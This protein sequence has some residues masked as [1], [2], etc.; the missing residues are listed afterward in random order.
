[1]TDN[2]DV[3]A[4][5]PCFCCPRYQ[6]LITWADHLE[7]IA[8][9][10]ERD[11]M[12]YLNVKADIVEN[13]WDSDYA[14]VGISGYR[15][16]TVPTQNEAALIQHFE[17]LPAEVIFAE[18]LTPVM[19][20][21]DVARPGLVSV[22]REKAGYAREL[23]ERGLEYCKS[24][25]NY[26]GNDGDAVLDYFCTLDPDKINQEVWNE[27]FKI[28]YID[29]PTW[30]DISYE[31]VSD[32]LFRIELAVAV[33]SVVFVWRAYLASIARLLTRLGRVA[34]HKFI[35]LTAKQIGRLHSIGRREMPRELVAKTKLQRVNLSGATDAEA[36]IANGFMGIGHATP[37]AE[38]SAKAKSAFQHSYSR[39]ADEF[40]LP[41]WKG[42]QATELQGMFNEAV[43]QVRSQ[44]HS[45]IISQQR[46]GVRGL[47]Y[48][49]QYTTMTEFRATLNG[50]EFF[51]YELRD[52]GKFVSAGKVK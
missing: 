29:L 11:F 46:Y 17:D 33:G 47:P 15:D 40:G 10:I 20:N 3:T 32:A 26:I 28:G 23:G 43:G 51:Y 27:L 2:S 9:K 42:S 39:H 45:V 52:I 37:Y 18:D 7:E 19:L 16:P 24:N 31:V 13:G 21:N 5:C 4:G 41:A 50:Q 1:M 8:V 6:E 36:G 48:P 38:M 34:G 14:K 25:R 49:A 44:A 22:I 35:R 12:F 30:Q